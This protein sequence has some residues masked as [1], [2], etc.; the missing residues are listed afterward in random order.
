MDYSLIIIA[1]NEFQ[2]NI[3]TLRILF[4]CGRM[5]VSCD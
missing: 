2:F 4:V 3:V 1:L 5:V